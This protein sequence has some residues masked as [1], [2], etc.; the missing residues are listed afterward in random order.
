MKELV[1]VVMKEM[2]GLH[3][4]YFEAAVCPTVKQGAL[5]FSYDEAESKKAKSAEILKSF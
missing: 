1:P 4:T 3:S 5:S 2:D